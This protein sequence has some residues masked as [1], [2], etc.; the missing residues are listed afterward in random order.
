MTARGAAYFAVPITGTARPPRRRSPGWQGKHVSPAPVEH[1]RRARQSSLLF[2]RALT[3]SSSVHWRRHCYR[4]GNRRRVKKEP[5]RVRMAF[6]FRLTTVNTYTYTYTSLYINRPLCVRSR[7]RYGLQRAVEYPNVSLSKTRHPP[8]LV[9]PKKRLRFTPTLNTIRVYKSDLV[10]LM[11][12]LTFWPKTFSAQN[13][14]TP[15]RNANNIYH[16]QTFWLVYD[17]I[18]KYIIINLIQTSPY[19]RDFFV[20]YKLL[21]K[22]FSIFY[23]LSLHVSY[24]SDKNENR[25]FLKF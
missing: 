25:F 11:L 22:Y 17:T 21:G 23:Y 2:H 13:I 24:S 3:I 9:T 16:Y 15:T 7:N 18:K 1:K 10:C 4:V 6:K 14:F 20:L 19:V 12:L 5:A 8:P